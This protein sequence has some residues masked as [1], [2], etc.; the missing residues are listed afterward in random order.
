MPVNL[1]QFLTGLGIQL[2]AGGII[3]FAAGYA[4]KKLA[5]IV[6]FILGV[7]ILALMYLNYAG[8]VDVRWEGLLGWGEE[9]LSWIAMHYSPIASFIIT[10]IPFASSFTV[11]FALGVKAA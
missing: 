11:G 5:K 6:A 4:L 3:G 7:F 1:T 9:A 8:I 2:G 10:N